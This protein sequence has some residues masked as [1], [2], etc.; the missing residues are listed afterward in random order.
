MRQLLDLGFENSIDAVVTDPPYHLTAGKRG[1][2][3]LA[4]VNTRS[5]AGRSMI[6]TGFMGKAWDGGDVAFRAETWDLVRRLLKPGGH[7]LGFGGTRTV[8]RLA[9]AIE[10]AGF[11][12]RDRIRYEYS[13]ETKFGPLWASL[14]DDQRGALLELLN[15]QDGLGSEVAWKHATG[16]PKSVDVSKAVE[17]MSLRHSG[18][19]HG[20]PATAEAA[21]WSGWGSALKPC[22]EPIIAARKP[23]DGTVAETVLQWGTG[24][25]NID[26]CRVG[27]G[28]G[29]TR[30]VSYPDIRG[31][32][33]GQGTEAY[34]ER[35]TIERTVTDNGRWPGNVIH[36]GS[37]E[38]EAA[39]AAFGERPGQQGRSSANAASPRTGGVYGKMGRSDASMA[40]RGDT[41]T[42][43]RFY[44]C[45]KACARDRMGKHPTQ[46]PLTL[47][48]HLCRLVTPPGGVV[49]DPFAGSGTTLEAALLEGFCA[50]GCE[51]TPDYWGDIEARLRRAQSGIAA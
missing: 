38:V 41:G 27:T 12:I 1:G 18:V 39:Y 40:P 42:A 9:V 5:P 3:G 16:F 25:I 32:N 20:A 36:D 23:L 10:D 14:T 44:F 8:H 24:G 45:A 13:P 19:K 4:S 29:K 37:E 43:S 49:M 2:T 21:R 35:A 11:E 48:R 17:K 15:D 7:L 46:K 50:L 33:Y 47:M 28:T 26:G 30:T 34:K 6:G 51:L 22:Y 31:G